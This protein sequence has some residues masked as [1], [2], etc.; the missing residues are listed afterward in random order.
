M[1]LWSDWVPEIAPDVPA[2]P[3]PLIEDAVRESVI[4]FLQRTRWLSG[5]NAVAADVIGGAVVRAF[6]SPLLAAGSQVLE[7]QGAWLSGKRLEVWSPE[8]AE[9][10]LGPT[11]ATQTGEP[12]AIVMDRLDGYYVV[13]APATTLTA[14]L[15]MRTATAPLATATSC[16]DTVRNRWREAIRNGAIARLCAMPEKAWTNTGRAAIGA[17]MYGSAVASAQVGAARRSSKSRLSVR[18]VFF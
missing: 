16:D 15:T 14:A 10:Q 6:A 11:W 3:E 9:E 1:A 7:V 5:V 2:C 18:G 17:G 8:E 13:P 4:D 12:R